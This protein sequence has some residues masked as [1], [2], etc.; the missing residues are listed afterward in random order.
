[1]ALVHFRKFGSI[2]TIDWIVQ[3]HTLCNVR[4]IQRTLALSFLTVIHSKIMS[5][6]VGRWI[7]RIGTAIAVVV[8][9]YAAIIIP[10]ENYKVRD[11]TR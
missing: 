9:L 6:L 7:S 3:Q 5:S 8:A 4:F 10:L 11:M 2:A 1:M